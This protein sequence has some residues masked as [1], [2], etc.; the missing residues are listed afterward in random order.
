MSDK[1]EEFKEKKRRETD[2]LAEVIEENSR[3]R[4]QRQ[5]LEE[6]SRRISIARQGRIHFEK[7][8]LSEAMQN[9]RRFLNITARSFDVEM[10]D[11]HPKYFEEKYRVSES[12][13]VSAICLDLA[14]ILDHIDSA[15]SRTERSLLLRLFVSFTLGMPFQFFVSENLRKFLQYSKTVEHRSEFDTAYQQI[16][17][18]NMCFVATAAFQSAEAPEVIALQRLRDQVLRKNFAGRMFIHFYYFIGPWLA[19]LTEIPG[20]RMGVKWALSRFV[21]AVSIT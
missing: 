10:K 8:E 18:H 21:R 11:M 2:R 7:N 3:R 14:K 12:L 5:F 4:D 6:L 20:A 19:K 17:K 9:Y 15:E 13:L 1:K 16:R